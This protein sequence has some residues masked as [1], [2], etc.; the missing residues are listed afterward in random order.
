VG[1]GSEE[2]ERAKLW[3]CNAVADS[4]EHVEE[5]AFARGGTSGSGARNK[6]N[7]TARCK[8]GELLCKPG[9]TRELPIYQFKSQR[10]ERS[11]SFSYGT[12]TRAIACGEA[13][14]N[15]PL[16]KRRD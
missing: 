2:A 15:L 7:A 6:W 4:C 1:L 16:F 5:F 8:V 11:K 12:C 10:T 13:S 3:D 9:V 14:C